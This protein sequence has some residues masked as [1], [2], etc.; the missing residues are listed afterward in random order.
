P[1]LPVAAVRYLFDELTTLSPKGME[2][3]LPSYLR[4]ILE[5]QE[6]LDS[7]TEYLIYNLAPEPEYEQETSERLSRL[8]DEQIQC[9]IKL[10]QHWQQSERWREYCPKELDRALQFLQ[11]RVRDA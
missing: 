10:V 5:A 1:E 9:L 7:S 3:V 8:S 11:S 2:W 6:N 4:C